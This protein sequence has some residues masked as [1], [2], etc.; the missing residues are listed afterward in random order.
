MLL[1]LPAFA[2]CFAA[3][4]AASAAERRVLITRV[5]VEQPATIGINI[6]FGETFVFRRLKETKRDLKR[7]KETLED[8]KRLKET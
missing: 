8:K 6:S 4:G 3:A 1:L 5:V 2:A 7:Q